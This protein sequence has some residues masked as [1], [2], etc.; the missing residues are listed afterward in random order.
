MKLK[1]KI[2]FAKTK[3]VKNYKYK[4]LQNSSIIIE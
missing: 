1:Q 4:N 2:Q 3:V